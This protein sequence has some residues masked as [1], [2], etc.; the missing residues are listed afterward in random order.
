MERELQNRLREIEGKVDSI[1]HLLREVYVPP[2]RQEVR[3]LLRKHNG[4]GGEVIK[5]LNQRN[6]ARYG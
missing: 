6:K 1:L 4:D 2:F 3:E 5:E